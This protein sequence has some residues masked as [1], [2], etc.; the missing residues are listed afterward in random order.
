MHGVQLS[1]I[2][3]NLLVALD[4]LVQERN[5]ARAARR[6]GLSPSA[7]SHTLARV[8]EMLGDPVLVRS[9][10]AMTVTPRAL[11]IAAPLREGLAS[12]SRALEKPAPLDLKRERRVVRLAAVDF[13]Q[14]HVVKRLA[15]RLRNEAPLVDLV[16]VGAGS[17]ALDELKSGAID[18]LI[19]A[20]GNLRGLA[21]RPLADEPFVCVVRR[22][23]PCL[24]SRFTLKRFAELEHVIVSPRGKTIGATDAGLRKKGLKRRVVLAV[25]TFLAAALVV[26]ETDLVL[27]CGARSARE[28]K[29]WLSLE[30]LPPPMKLPPFTLALFWDPRTEH[31]PFARYIRDTIA[32]V[33]KE[34]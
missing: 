20:Q 33:A 29:T 12:I 16:T 19:A 32:D 26:A 3:A 30:V 11:E 1:S 25:P 5:V 8:R 9:G 31:D 15:V 22:G 14:N 21:R 27:T 24:S 13:A 28:A 23:H 10:R 17:S 34:R 6:V 4:A 18:A 2:D 7:M